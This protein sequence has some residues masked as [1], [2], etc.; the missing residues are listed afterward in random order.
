MNKLKALSLVA[1]AALGLT[2]YGGTTTNEW[3]NVT[4]EPGSFQDGF[5]GLTIG[6]LAALTNDASIAQVTQPYTNGVW[7]MIDGDESYVTNGLVTNFVNGAMTE[8]ANSVYLKLD[9]QGNDLTW[10]AKTNDVP[11]NIKALVDADLLLVGSDSAPDSTDFDAAGDVH[12]A[13][14]LKNETDPD[15]GETTNSVLCVYVFDG[16]DAR[17]WQEL[18]GVELEDN[19]WAHV[20][21][22]VD[23]TDASSPMVQVFVNGTQMHASGDASTVSWPA[24]VSAGGGNFYKLSSVAFRGTGAVDN[25]VG[26]T[27][28]VTYDK[29]YFKAEVYLDGKVTNEL[30]QVTA[31]QFDIGGLEKP[32]FAGFSFDN[33]AET[34]PDPA[35]YAL[36]KIEIIDFANDRTRTYEYD[37]DPDDEDD[38]GIYM[39]PKP[40]TEETEDIYFDPDPVEGYQVGT[41][42]VKAPTAGAVKP[43]DENEP[44]TIVKIYFKSLGAYEAKAETV[45]G[46]VYT[47]N[48]IVVKTN[49]LPA[50]PTWEFPATTN[51]A[52]LST[53]QVYENAA[54]AYANSKA[55]VSV[56]ISDALAADTLFVTATYTNGTLAAGQTLA[57]D[58]GVSGLYTF[59]VVEGGAPVTKPEVDVGEGLAAYNAQLGPDDAPVQPIAFAVPEGGQD[60]LCTL[61][62]VAPADGWYFLYTSTTVAGPYLPDYATKKQVSENDLVTL[63][64]S[65]AG[66]SKFFKIGWSETDPAAE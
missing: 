53:I 18:D 29:A 45:I 55:T 62:F 63:T 17:Y 65:A 19:A 31:K 12:T 16:T 2:A 3:W 7:K 61:A 66:T 14:Y 35:T 49:E 60:A 46:G 13:I 1:L 48:S 20:Q 59:A 23:Y 52:I 64:E 37:Y 42:S 58:A 26:E 4:L 47:T 21:V 51:G 28:K 38:D 56:T 15:S 9:T 50:T 54:L 5:P 57:P 24:A 25:F 6:E 27:Q 33:F 41:F 40:G 11:D 32:S 36:S 44:V 22:V 39:E 30:C 8:V 43:A 10:D 34:D